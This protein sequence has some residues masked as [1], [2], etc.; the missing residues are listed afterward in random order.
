VPGCPNNGQAGGRRL[1]K[2]D[3]EHTTEGAC[4]RKIVPP[5]IIFSWFFPLFRFLRFALNLTD[6]TACVSLLKG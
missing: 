2:M 1:Y 3:T 6:E 4:G 5:P